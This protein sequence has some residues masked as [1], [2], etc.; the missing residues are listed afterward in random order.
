MSE[1]R[2]MIGPAG[3]LKPEEVEFVR[4]AF[5]YG[6]LPGIVARDLDCSVL[7]IRRRYQRLRA[8]QVQ[9]KASQ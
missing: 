3:H 5:E 2:C 8:E 6:W 7:A 9:E 1:P 4:Q